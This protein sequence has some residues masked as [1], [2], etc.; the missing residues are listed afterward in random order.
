MWGD[1]RHSL[2]S[3]EADEVS[4]VK[5]LKIQTH[6]PSPCITISWIQIHMTNQYSTYVVTI[7]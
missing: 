6:P 5:Q 3:G 2:H 1:L 4:I 7:G